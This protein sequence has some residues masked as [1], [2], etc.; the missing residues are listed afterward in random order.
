MIIN[1]DYPNK[2]PELYCLTVFPHPHLCD[3]RNLLND[4]INGEWNKKKLPLETLINKIPNFIIKYNELI[5]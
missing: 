1:K 2:D 3:G 5:K 4:I